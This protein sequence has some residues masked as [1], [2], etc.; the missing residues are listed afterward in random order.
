MEVTVMMEDT[1][2]VQ[3]DASVLL[4]QSAKTELREWSQ[5]TLTTWE[6]PEDTETV[7]HS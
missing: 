1:K 3:A 5:P 6:V 2:N 7:P 4:D